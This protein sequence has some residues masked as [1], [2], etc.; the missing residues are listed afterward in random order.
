M[1]AFAIV[2]DGGGSVGICYSSGWWWVWLEFAFVA[3]GGGD[4]GD[5]Y[6]RGWMREGCD[7]L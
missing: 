2:V 3:V 6:I 4:S 7:F 5:C 1:L